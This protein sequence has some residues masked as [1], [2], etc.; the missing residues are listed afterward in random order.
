MHTRTNELHVFSCA[1]VLSI[2]KW[3]L[4]R[5]QMWPLMRIMTIGITGIASCTHSIDGGAH[6]QYFG[7]KSCDK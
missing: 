6:L 1:S 3:Q 7:E 5:Q 4:E 2:H